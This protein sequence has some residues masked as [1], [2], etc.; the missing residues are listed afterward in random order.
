MPYFAGGKIAVATARPINTPA[1]RLKNNFFILLRYSL[2][3]TTTLRKVRCCRWP[4]GRVRYAGLRKSQSDRPSL[5]RLSTGVAVRSCQAEAGCSRRDGR[6]GGVER[7]LLHRDG[8]LGVESQTPVGDVERACADAGGDLRQGGPQRTGY[9]LATRL[10]DGD[11]T[12]RHTEVH[13]GRVHQVRHRVEGAVL[14]VEVAVAVDQ[15]V[16]VGHAEGAG[17]DAGVDFHQRTAE[18]A[19]LHDQLA[20]GLQD[21]DPV[22]RHL[23]VD[24][25]GVDQDPRRIDGTSLRVQVA[26][27]IEEDDPGAGGQI[28]DVPEVQEAH[29]PQCSRC[30]GPFAVGAVIAVHTVAVR[31]GVVV[32]RDLDP[33]IRV[34][35]LDVRDVSVGAGHLDGRSADG[36]CAVVRH[37][38]GLRVGRPLVGVAEVAVDG[39][40]NTVRREPVGHVV[41]AV[42]VVVGVRRDRVH[43]LVVVRVATAGLGR[44]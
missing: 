11:P 35:R 39:R 18:A 31:V 6:P 20:A 29:E 43:R 12:G 13:H 23:V 22:G 1:K 16:G 10:Q 9:Q 40:S 37:S 3:L 33:A 5:E 44:G 27:A 15:Q 28:R 14:V 36:G 42:L 41:G 32:L 26:R 34:H 30:A 25:A 2:W 38:L 7:T 4:A 24:D 21:G 8:A 19:L 17:A